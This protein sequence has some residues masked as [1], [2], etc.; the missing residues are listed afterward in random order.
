MHDRCYGNWE[1]SFQDGDD[2]FVFIIDMYLYLDSAS[3]VMVE[4][5]ST[6]HFR[7]AAMLNGNLVPRVFTYARRCD[8]DPGSGWSRDTPKSGVFLISDLYFIGEGWQSTIC[9]V[10]A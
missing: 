1:K 3:V 2:E 10:R 4:A 6:S 5:G 9:R 8:K 7:M